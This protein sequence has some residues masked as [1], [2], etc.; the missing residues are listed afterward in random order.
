LQVRKSIVCEPLREEEETRAL[1]ACPGGAPATL[2]RD[3][4]WWRADQTAV[5]VNP[6]TLRGASG[7]L[8]GL[9]TK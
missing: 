6:S 4:C 1:A 5:V 7:M 8:D 2:T 3:V 9:V